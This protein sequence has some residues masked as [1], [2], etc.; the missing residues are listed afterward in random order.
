MRGHGEK[1]SRKTDQFIAALMVHPGVEAAAESVGISH[2]TAWRWM[3]DPAF[4]ERFREVCRDTMNRAIARLQE[5][6]SDA[7]DCLRKVQSTGESESARVSA[8]RTILEHALRAVELDDIQVRLDKLEQ[9]A[10][11]ANEKGK[12][13]GEDQAAT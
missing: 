2:A 9:I 8:A 10:K 11:S 3:K 4:I 5:A 7:V 12:H 1:K 6:A 13:E